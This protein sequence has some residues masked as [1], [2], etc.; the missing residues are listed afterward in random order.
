MRYRDTD[1]RAHEFFKRIGPQNHEMAQCKN[2]DEPKKQPSPLQL[3]GQY[4]QRERQQR[5]DTGV[6]RNNE[7]GL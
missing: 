2:H 6:N 1:P 3:R 4:R 5:Y 7:A